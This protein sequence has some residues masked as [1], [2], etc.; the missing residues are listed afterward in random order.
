MSGVVKVHQSVDLDPLI[1]QN[2]IER[3]SASTGFKGETFHKMAS[4]API[5][6]DM[7]RQEL[8]AKGYDNPDPLA[9]E[10]K[11]WLIAK[12]NSRDYQKLR[13]KEGMI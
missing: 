3:N 11:M 13:T 12:L 6:L 10:N 7:W 5:V 2:A 4:V 8:K 1:K 9:K